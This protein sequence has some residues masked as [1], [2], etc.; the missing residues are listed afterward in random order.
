LTDV[1]DRTLNGSTAL[2]RA[3]RAIGKLQF[4]LAGPSYFIDPLRKMVYRRGEP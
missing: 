2:P 4:A 1:N 3:G